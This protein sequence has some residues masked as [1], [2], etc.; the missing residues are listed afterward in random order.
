LWKEASV[1]L[2]YATGDATVPASAG[3][4]L[5]AHVCNDRGGWGKGFVVAISRRWPQ[6]ERDYRTWSRTPDFQLGAV[7]LVQVETDTWV[8]NMVAQRGYRS[9]SNPT[10]LRYEALEK[11][12]NDLAA[13]AAR[14]SASVHMPRIGCG[15]AGGSWD[16]IGPML[17]RA[18]TS[19]GI[20]TTVYDLEQPTR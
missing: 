18:L 20:A 19:A 17:D 6:P 16:E 4:K 14:L 8:A 3:N 15:L 13:H 12:L 7:R 9:A 1:T 11:C 2:L 5:I 10:P